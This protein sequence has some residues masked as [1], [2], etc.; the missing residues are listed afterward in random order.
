M[1][2]LD[3]PKTDADQTRQR[4]L[5]AAEV[6]FAE[7]GREAASV[8]DILKRAGVR[9][10]AAVNYHFGDKDSLY[11]A[12][13]KN[14]HVSCCAIKFPEWPAGTPPQDKLRD[15]IRTVVLRMTAPPRPSALQV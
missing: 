9:N 14:A 6:V 4:I 11:I 12:V 13:V 10:I 7:K 15:F 8:R 2:S 1:N 3:D 5:E